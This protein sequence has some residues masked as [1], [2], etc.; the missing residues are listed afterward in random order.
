MECE[1]EGPVPRLR[2]ALRLL[3]GLGDEIEHVKFEVRRALRDLGACGCAKWD[4][5][6][7][8]TCKSCTIARTTSEKPYLT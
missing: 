1:D 5:A 2:Q 8:R 3:E 4:A 7:E 6:A